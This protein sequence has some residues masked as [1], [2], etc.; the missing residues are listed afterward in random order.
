MKLKEFSAYVVSKLKPV[1]PS[2]IEPSKAREY[3]LTE[4][5]VEIKKLRSGEYFGELA[6]IKDA[7]RAATIITDEISS[8]AVIEKVAYKNVLMKIDAKQKEQID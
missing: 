5:F 7:P 3:G 1:I 6:L 4:W 2:G 8:F